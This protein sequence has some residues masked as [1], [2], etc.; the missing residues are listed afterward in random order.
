MSNFWARTITGL[1]M[2]FMLLFSLWY[3]TWLF[4]G[5]FLVVAILGMW[6]FFTLYSSDE[7]QPQKIYGTISGSIIYLLLFLVNTSGGSDVDSVVR[8]LPVYAAMALFFLCFIIEI[9]RKKPKPLENIAITTTGVL[10]I[11][12][13]LALLNLM[14]SASSTRMFGFPA[15]LAGYFTLTWFYDTAAYLFGKQFGKHKLFERISPKKTWEGTI[16]GALVTTL[17]SLLL[18]YMVPGI[19]LTDWLVLA[20]L[21]VIFG[22]FGDLAESLLKR[23]LNIKDSGTILP[24]HGGILDRFDTFFISAPFVFLYFV[25]RNIL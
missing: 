24:G 25:L 6:E 14:V 21:V 12:L 10:Y 1:S 18:S 4:A 3:N 22:S 9:Y 16:A 15:F 13:P 19:S 8:L 20:L 7:I 17:T 11:A 5:I 2:V 23:S